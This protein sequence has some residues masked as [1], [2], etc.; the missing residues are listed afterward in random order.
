MKGGLSVDVEGGRVFIPASL[1]S[2]VFERDLNKYL[3]QEI[4]F[5]V[6]E[7]DPRKR[8]IIGDR[9][10]L[11]VEQK[12]AA[13]KALFDKIAVGDVVEGVVKSVVDFGAFIDIGGADGLL[14]ISEMSWGRVGNPRKMFKPGDKVKTFIKEIN[15][16]KIALSLKFEDT[17]PWANASEKFAVGVIVTGKVARMTDFGAFVEI[18]PGVD[19][20]L[21]VSQIARHH[22]EK[23]ADELKIGQEIEAKIVDFNEEEKK[24]SLSMKVLLPEEPK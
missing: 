9:K 5:V 3:N 10:Q 17:N 7:F 8:R 2:D 22:V 1:V 20:L 15:G 19:G 11:I 13:K 24:I 14:H 6:T 12:E 16:D 21:H 4:E 23:P 18:E